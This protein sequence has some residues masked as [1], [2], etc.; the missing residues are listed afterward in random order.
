MLPCGRNS[1]YH[2]CTD[3]AA[4][5]ARGKG[6]AL[7]LRTMA[8]LALGP[9]LGLALAPP[10]LAHHVMDGALP[11]TAW[12]GLLSGLGHPVIGVDHLAFVV[13]VGAMAYLMGRVVL[14][15]LVL[16]GGTIAGCVLHIHGYNLPAPELVVAATV[17]MAAALVAMRIKPSGGLLAGF[18]AVAGLFHGYAYGES[19][20]GAETAPLAAYVIG[21]GIIQGC[22]AVGAALALRAVVGRHYL[23]EAAAMGFAGVGL[24][25]VAAVALAT[26]A[27][28][29]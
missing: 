10:A 24:A 19:I 18:L 25:L 29:G 3:M 15:P 14:L 6:M 22:I 17:A 11:G 9:T 28:A 4:Q 12:Q 27:L 1:A 8:G 26:A 23:T 7:I 2:A 21:F 16:V 13:G 20:V 5:A